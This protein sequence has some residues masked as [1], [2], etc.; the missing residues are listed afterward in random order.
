MPIKFPKGFARRKSSGN[1][2]EEVE[3]PPQHSFRVFERP[4]SEGKLAHRFGSAKHNADQQSLSSVT[5]DFDNIFAGTERPVPQNRY[6]TPSLLL[7]NTIYNRLTIMIARSSGGTDRSTVTAD[8]YAS[9]SSTKFGS[10]STLPSSADGPIQN[11]V[12]SP[13]SRSFYDIPVPPLAS[14]LR[15]AGRTFSFGSSGKRPKPSTPSTPPVKSPSASS[16]HRAMTASTT[17]TTTPP[18]LL[19][20]DLNLDSSDGFGNMFEN[21]GKRQS[22]L[23]QM[24][25]SQDG[26]DKVGPSK[27]SSLWQP[28][29][30][31]RRLHQAAIEKTYLLDWRPSTLTDQ[32]RWSLRLTL[33]TADI[34]TKGF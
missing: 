34:R 9:S 23:L 31:T 12:S 18:K 29:L 30:M 6:G 3:T 10:S 5:E 26:T 17:S 4:T 20:S 1:A 13:H 32:R 15:N 27:T 19:D 28:L 11:D 33:G 7:H 24:S 21:F 16:R 8:L 14:A 25:T 2:L 22:A